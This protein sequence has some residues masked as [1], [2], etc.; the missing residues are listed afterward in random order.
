MKNVFLS[1][2]GRTAILHYE[3]F[4]ILLWQLWIEIKLIIW[5]SLWKLEDVLLIALR[6]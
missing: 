3:L 6:I 2:F 1:D 5:K 4:K